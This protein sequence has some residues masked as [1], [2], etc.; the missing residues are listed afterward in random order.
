QGGAGRYGGGLLPILSLFAG[1]TLLF[2]GKYPESLRLL[3]VGMN[4]WTYRVLVYATLMTDVY[5]P[6]RLED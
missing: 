1:A 4:R 6:F 5:P 3:I 2:T